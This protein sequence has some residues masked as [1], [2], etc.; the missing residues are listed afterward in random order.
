MQWFKKA[1]KSVKE[2]VVRSK[3]EFIDPTSSEEEAAQ[4]LIRINAEKN[5]QVRLEDL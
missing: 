4:E 3:V 1:A 5:E 2:T